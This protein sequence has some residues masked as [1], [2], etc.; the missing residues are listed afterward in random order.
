MDIRV[1][2]SFAMIRSSSVSVSRKKLKQK[3]KQQIENHHLYKCLPF[4]K[5]PNSETQMETKLR[6]DID[7]ATLAGYY[8]LKT[9]STKQH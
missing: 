2:I 9:T 7:V 8:P 3:Y 6:F 4:R 5:I 1:R